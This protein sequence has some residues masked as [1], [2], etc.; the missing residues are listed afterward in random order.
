[1]WWKGIPR[2]FWP[3]VLDKVVALADRIRV[4]IPHDPG[5]PV[6]VTVTSMEDFQLKIHYYGK[7]QDWNRQA[8]ADKPFGIGEGGSM[9]WGLPAVFSLYN[10]ER[11]YESRLG[12]QEG[13][14][15]E[16]YWYLVEQRKISAFTSI[17][18]I[19]G[20]CFEPFPLGGGDAEGIALG[21]FIEGQPGIQPERMPA[22]ATYNPGY[23]LS[24][25]LY[26]TNPVFD[27]I[28]AAYSPGVPVPSPWDHRVESKKPAHHHQRQQLKKWNSF[29]CITGGFKKSI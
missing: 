7:P 11:S 24:Q 4:L 10:G 23:D 16:L 27:A 9:L 14:A 12:M 6:M 19:T 28:K 8:P 20:S 5:F 25:P 18:T 1:M 15:I 22:W 29:G 21:P 26:K 2:K 13:I 17:F 3:P